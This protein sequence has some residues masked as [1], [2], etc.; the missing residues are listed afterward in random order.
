MESAN[1]NGLCFDLKELMSRR[2]PMLVHTN[3]HLF[4]LDRILPQSL[5][6]KVTATAV[7]QAANT[8]APHENATLATIVKDAKYEGVERAQETPYAIE[9]AVQPSAPK[10]I[11]YSTEPQLVDRIKTNLQA[12]ITPKGTPIMFDPYS[13][14]LIEGR[15]ALG[16]DSM[17]PK[18]FETIERAIVGN[19][20]Y[21]GN[22]MI[23]KTGENK[24]LFYLDKNGFKNG[25]EAELLKGIKT[26][27]KQLSAGRQAAVVLVSPSLNLKFPAIAADKDRETEIPFEIGTNGFKSDIY[28]MMMAD[29]VN[30]MEYAHNILNR[31]G[32]FAYAAKIVPG[33]L[34]RRMQFP[35]FEIS[36]S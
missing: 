31:A 30:Y 32:S 15:N 4:G 24:R 10:E 9:A 20:L 2:M 36:Y 14:I 7:P 18:E 19:H 1:T 23:V 13:L 29:A 12:T 33:G 6:K 5:H 25:E 16:S 3:P 11:V 34:G 21:R 28:K 35:T 8:Q 26:A 22:S 17:S 27:V